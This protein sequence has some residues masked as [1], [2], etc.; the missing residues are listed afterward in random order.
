MRGATVAMA[1]G[2]HRLAEHLLA[3]GARVTVADPVARMEGV[4]VVAPDDAHRVEC[5]IYSPNAYGAV[6]SEVTIPELRCAAVCGAANNQLATPEDV[7][8]A[9]AYFASEPGHVT[10]QI[11]SVSG[12]LTMA[13]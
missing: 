11:L 2:D 12:G 4:G 13:G 7:A 3:V 9:V 8:A 1:A 6:L 10:G 5:D